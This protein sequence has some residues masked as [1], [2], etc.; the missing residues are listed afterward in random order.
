MTYLLQKFLSAET[1]QNDCEV[2]SVQ[3]AQMITTLSFVITEATEYVP[4]YLKRHVDRHTKN[5]T[6]I[7]GTNWIV[8]ND[9][10]FYLVSAVLH[11]GDNIESGHYTTIRRMNHGQWLHFEDNH[12]H[13]VQGDP[14]TR[15]N[16]GVYPFTIKY[17]SQL[18]ILMYRKF[19]QQA[20]QNVGF[21][22][23]D[24]NP[25]DTVAFKYG[26]NLQISDLLKLMPMGWLNDNI[27]DF[28]LKL[29][30]EQI[31]LQNATT[32]NARGCFFFSSKFYTKLTKE[33]TSYDYELV[34]RWTRDT[35]IFSK[36]FII[37]PIHQTAH[38][39]VAAIDILHSSIIYYDPLGNPNPTFH[40]NILKYLND[41]A[42]RLNHQF[43]RTDWTDAPPQ[44][45]P[46]QRNGYD[47][48]MHVVLFAFCISTG[49]QPLYQEADMPTF[50]CKICKDLIM[51]KC[52]MNLT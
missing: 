34:S 51:G 37:I 41:E 22:L 49:Q 1:M 18:Y 45:F 43:N 5:H 17:G 39:C 12:C 27:I 32:P 25:N 19:T 33:Y 24:H 10:P 52:T 15:T 31:D 6:I 35:N 21:D 4:I 20:H 36:D 9:C 3:N 40:E 23:S 11:H 14:L 42:N 29:V 8:L 16:A 2:C 50:R 26:I 48:G 46:Q 13:S 28:Y 7:S 38:W 47:C 44:G 30:N